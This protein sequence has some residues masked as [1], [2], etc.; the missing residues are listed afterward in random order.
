MAHR[1]TDARFVG[2]GGMLTESLVAITPGTFGV[3]KEQ[4]SQV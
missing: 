4:V 1:E 2:Y 3:F